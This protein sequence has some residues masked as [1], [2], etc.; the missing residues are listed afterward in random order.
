MAIDR[1]LTLVRR[2][3]GTD[4][5]DARDVGPKPDLPSPVQ[6]IKQSAHLEPLVTLGGDVLFGRV[7]PSDER[8]TSDVY[9]LSD[10]DLIATHGL[11][12]GDNATLAVSIV[13]R[14]R[15]GGGGVVFD[16]TLHGGDVR[17][18]LWREVFRPPLV[19]ATGSAFFAGLVLVAA[20]LGRF[21]RENTST[22]ST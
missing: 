16:E 14:L 13:E 20:G 4:E 3:V 22:I 18:S 21:G 6:L 2:P 19:F 9:V 1:G 15:P 10:P 7:L 11:V 12:R 5:F 8:S 17:P